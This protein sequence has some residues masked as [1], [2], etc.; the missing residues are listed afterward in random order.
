MDFKDY[1]KVMGIN[2]DST[3]DEIKRA[4]KKLAR[5]YHPDVN[6]AA[7]AEVRFKEV[8]EAYA[9]LKDPDKRASYDQLGND[10]QSG[11]NF[12]PP[13]DWDA[14]F[15]FKEGGASGASQADFSDFFDSLFGKGYSSHKPNNQHQADYKARGEDY[16]AKVV[17]DLEDAYLGA[18]RSIVLQSPELDK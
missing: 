9:V 8:G 14:G 18:T 15:E 3:S 6:K 5:K 12:N 7:D 10:W 4:Y 16:H 17:I 13:P 2:R 1:Y 11:Q